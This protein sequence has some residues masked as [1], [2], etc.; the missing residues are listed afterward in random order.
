MIENNELTNNHLAIFYWI[1][2][3]I[4]MVNMLVRN[5]TDFLSFL[6]IF[7]NE[8]RRLTCFWYI[9]SKDSF[10]T[11]NN[12]F[13]Y[14]IKL[15]LLTI[16]FICR[17][18]SLTRSIFFFKFRKKL[19]VFYFSFLLLVLPRYLHSFMVSIKVSEAYFLSYYC[20]YSLFSI[21]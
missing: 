19:L 13:I 14:S 18:R 21:Q 4:L 2:V 3:C 8:D 9:Y 6:Y 17:F 10:K 15:L 20:F 16:D 11:E 1:R 7:I 12:R 5:T